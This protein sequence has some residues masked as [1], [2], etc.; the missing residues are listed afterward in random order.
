MGGTIGSC[1]NCINEISKISD[2][3]VE[4]ITNPNNYYGKNL[5]DFLKK[6]DDL[7]RKIIKIQSCFRSRMLRKEIYKHRNIMIKRLLPNSGNEKIKTRI[8]STTSSIFEER[9]KDLFKKHSPLKDDIN[10]CIKIIEYE[11]DSVYYGEWNPKTKERHG[12]GINVWQCKSIYEGF[13]KYNK[14]NGYGSLFNYEGDKYEGNWVDN[15]AFG[16]GVYTHVNGAFYSGNWYNDKQNGTGTEHWIDGSIYEGTF[17]NGA[18]SGFGTF[19]WSDGSCY[20]GDVK[21][22]VISGRGQYTWNDKRFYFGEWKLN[23]MNGTGEFYWPDGRKYT[24]T[25]L[26]DKKHGIGTF[27][28]SDGKIFKGNWENGKQ[29]GEGS[30]FNPKTNT[31]KK[32][33]WKNGVKLKWLD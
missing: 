18:K 23:K 21:Q 28:W 27:Y 32:G 11:N 33:I 31:W 29:N 19:I 8:M 24:G 20:K 14:A 3:P 2:I 5:I 30:F 16:H 13:F 15:Q 7:L 26:D 1:N 25:Y 6:N 9:L 10:V 22:N 4:N 12:R 17:L